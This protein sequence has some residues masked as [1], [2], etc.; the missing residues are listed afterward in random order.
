MSFGAFLATVPLQVPVEV[1]ANGTEL[2]HEIEGSCD[3]SE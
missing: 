2:S 1:L 3:N